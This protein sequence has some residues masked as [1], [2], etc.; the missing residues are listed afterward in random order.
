[1]LEKRKK[2]PARV[3]VDTDVLNETDKPEQTGNVFNIWYYNWGAKDGTQTK[4]K[5]R[6]D[7]KKDSGYTRAN[8]IPDSY[9]CLFFAR[10]CCHKG[11]NC[12]YLH[13]LP[14][15]KKDNFPATKDCFGRDKFSDYRD[16]MGGVGNFLVTNKTL[17]LGQL[18][19][20]EV[21]RGLTI[22][23]LIT[24]N[25]QE[26]GQ[27]ERLRVIHSRSCGFLTFKDE[28]SAQFAKEAMA[29][30]SIVKNELLNIRWANEDPDPKAKERGQR[31]EELEAMAAIQTILDK[32]SKVAED[33]GKEKGKRPGERLNGQEKKMKLAVKA[34]EKVDDGA[35]KEAGRAEPS[36]IAGAKADGS[37]VQNQVIN[38]AADQLISG[39]DSSD[40]DD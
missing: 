22:E 15:S 20:D 32:N 23:E 14:S 4:S 3:Q 33:R 30:Q 25:F 34:R 13:R 38:H 8:K 26:F 10:G 6:V 12:E 36:K 39:Y 37:L 1:M 40:S 9:I 24:S 5:F 29:H 31:Q 21:A 19:V 17:Y 16:D 35:V 7:I 27:V 11:K 28:W 18:L 2:K